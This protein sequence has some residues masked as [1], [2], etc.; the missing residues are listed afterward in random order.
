MAAACGIAI[1]NLDSQVLFWNFLS[2][3]MR[4]CGLFLPL[5]FAIFYPRS[6]AKKWAY[7]SIVVS[8]LVPVCLG[9][10]FDVQADPLCIGLLISAAMMFVGYKRRWHP[11]P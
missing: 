1:V 11:M 6:V 10:F 5:T 3:A 9:L 7:A 4:G 2:M 8:T